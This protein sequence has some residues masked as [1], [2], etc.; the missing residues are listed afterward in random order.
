MDNEELHGVSQVDLVREFVKR[1]RVLEAEEE[2]IR[3]AKKDLR[4]EFKD[5]ID[6]KVLACAM[7]VVKIKERVQHKGTFEDIMELLEKEGLTQ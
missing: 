4:D 6:L 3:E 5:R 7:Q 1:M 2:T